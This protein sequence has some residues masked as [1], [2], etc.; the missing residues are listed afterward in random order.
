MPFPARQ[1]SIV[2]THPEITPPGYFCLGGVYRNPAPVVGYGE[3]F[4][5]LPPQLEDLPEF[6]YTR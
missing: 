3:E 6:P 2:R 5:A 1:A 4:E